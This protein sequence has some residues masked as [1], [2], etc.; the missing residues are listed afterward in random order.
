MRTGY[1]QLFAAIKNP[2]LYFFLNKPVVTSNA[3]SWH[4]HC[5]IL[6]NCGA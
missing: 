3:M 6:A 4:T 2:L 1:K 5:N